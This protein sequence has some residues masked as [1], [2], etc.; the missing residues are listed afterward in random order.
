MWSLVSDERYIDKSNVMHGTERV[1]SY[2]K[3]INEALEQ[4]MLINKRIYCMGQGINDK[5]G[6]WGITNLLCDKFSE[7]RVFDTPLSENGMMGIAIGS[8]VAGM[9]PIYFHNRPDFLW[10]TMDQLVNHAT[11]YNYMSG[12]QCNVPL[13]IWAATGK[14]W[15]SAAQHSQALQAIFMHIPGCKVIM[16]TTPYDAKGLMISSIIDNNPVLI[17]DHRLILN[18]DGYVPEEMYKIPFGEGVVRKEG[19]DVTL[20]GIS[21]MAK[22]VDKAAVKLEKD[23]IDAE[24]IDLRTIKP[25]DE[26]LV[27]NSVKKTGRLVI[28]DTSWRTGGVSAE[29]ASTVYEKAFESIK[30]PIV[31]LG[32][33]DVPTPASYSL[34][35]A[36]YKNAD[37]IYESVK[38]LF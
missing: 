15:G 7:E 29:I 31:R 32:N 27:I 37:D 38:Q 22:E 6:Y 3:A 33:I 30:C 2:V 10:L 28:A 18:Q 12:G 20:I 16:P 8:A 9:R 14:G 36:F 19:K 34:E 35:D 13:V 11:K 5:N 21:L 23:G 17:L 26:E 4:T 24:I 25:W 1:I